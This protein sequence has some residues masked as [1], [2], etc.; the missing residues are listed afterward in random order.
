MDYFLFL[1][2]FVGF[3]FFSKGSRNLTF[4]NFHQWLQF[5]TGK[6]HGTK[7]NKQKN[8]QAEQ[9]S[10][11]LYSPFGDLLKRLVVRRTYPPKAVFYMS[12]LFYNCPREVHTHSSLTNG[13]TK[14]LSNWVIEIQ[15]PDQSRDQSPA[16]PLTLPRGPILPGFIQG[17]P[18][19]VM[20]PCA[21][22]SLRR[23]GLE[24]LCWAPLWG[25]SL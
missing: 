4:Y 16:P 15:G 22:A 10:S 6:L 24:M 8:L 5:C 12:L 3:F 21:C 14:G 17:P 25:L 1:E 9:P 2:G 18:L 20:G 23:S 13:K 19:C 7:T 11:P